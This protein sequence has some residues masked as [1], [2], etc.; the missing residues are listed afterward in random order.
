M[1]SRGPKKKKKRK[2]DIE[3]NQEKNKQNSVKCHC[4]LCF[5]IPNT[6]C[7]VL[8]LCLKGNAIE[9]QKVDNHGNNMPD[10]RNE[11]ASSWRMNEG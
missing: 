7:K 1:L 3:K 5:L 10:Q 9:L 8:V 11:T 6:V 2:L 4:M